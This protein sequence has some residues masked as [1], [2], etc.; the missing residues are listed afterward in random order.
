VALRGGRVVLQVQQQVVRLLQGLPGVWKL[1]ARK[2]PLPPIDLHCP[3]LSLPRVF[4]TDAN[5][6]PA[7]V[8]YLHAEPDARARWRARIA[9]VPGP[10]DGLRVGLVWAGNPSH[11]N[12][13]NRS[14]PFDKLAPLLLNLPGMRWFSLQVGPA[15]ADLQG[16]P[17]G[18]VEDLAP[19]L[20]DFAE[21]AAAVSELDLVLAVDT[22]CAHLA[23]ALGVPTWMLVPFSPDWRWMLHREDSPWYP[24]MRL[25]RQAHFNDWDGVLGRIAGELARRTALV[26]A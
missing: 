12:D 19:E 8:P 11:R 4:G 24:T 26:P 23:G 15:Q 2:E 14:V 16:L 9:G 13:R 10:R 3:L 20:T 5:N 21:T 7:P 1:V 25:F 22:S 18:L 6:I 17:P